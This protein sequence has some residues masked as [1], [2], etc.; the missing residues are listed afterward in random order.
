M[1]GLRVVR[2]TLLGDVEPTRL[3]TE[4]KNETIPHETDRR[5]VSSRLHL[6]LLINGHIGVNLQTVTQHLWLSLSVA[7]TTDDEDV[8]IRGLGGGSLERHVVLGP[9]PLEL[10]LAE[11]LEL[12][13]E[14]E[15]LR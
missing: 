15:D 7:E 12:E 8:G 13:V 1:I 6:L 5:S 2:L 4:R 10:L 3:T 9:S 11:A 14:E